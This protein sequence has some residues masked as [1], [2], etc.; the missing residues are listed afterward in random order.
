MINGYRYVGAIVGWAGSGTI[1][2]NCY[3][4][5]DVTSNYYYTGGIAGYSNGI[6]SNCYNIADITGCGQNVG[7]IAGKC[8]QVRYCY[9][10]GYITADSSR[11]SSGYQSRDYIGGIVGEGQA[12]YCYNTGSVSGMREIGGI[13]GGYGG[14]QN[15]YNTGSVS[16]SSEGGGVGGIVGYQSYDIYNC[17][18]YGSV[19]ASGNLGGTIFKS[20]GWNCW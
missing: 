17:I 6:I 9:N 20:G 4:E 10:T 3:N 19:Y 7:G 1:V 13:V 11:S 2:D 16:G 12:Y 8:S 15:C 5:V 14:A 18:N